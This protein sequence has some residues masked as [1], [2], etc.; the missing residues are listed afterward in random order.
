MD[1][2]ANR[3]SWRKPPLALPAQR[4]KLKIERTFTDKDYNRLA[5]GLIPSAMEDKW[6]IFMENDTLFF[7][8]SWTGVCV[9][10]VHFDNRHCFNEIWVNRDSQQYKETDIEYDGKLLIFLIDNLL[11]GKNTPFPIPSNIP[12][13]LPKGLYQHNVS[14]MGYPEQQHQS[15][16]NWKTKLMRFFHKGS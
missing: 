11:L 7:H 8:R 15:K 5:Q 16:E 4:T 9:Y 13:N 2:I 6:F 12:S 1:N 14:G 10:E 3:N